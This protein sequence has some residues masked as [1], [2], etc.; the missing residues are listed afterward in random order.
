M[1]KYQFFRHIFNFIIF[2]VTYI[3]VYHLTQIHYSFYNMIKKNLLFYI[4]YYVL[5]YWQVLDL[6]E[7][8]YFKSN[9]NILIIY[10]LKS[11][12]HVLQIIMFLEFILIKFLDCNIQE[13][14]NINHLFVNDNNILQYMG[15]LIIKLFRFHR[16]NLL[17]LIYY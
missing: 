12:K 5:K 9:V 4:Y 3:L 14:S 7:L 1:T 17:S 8:Y 2:M 16:I 6:C 11:I 10:L 15:S 13:S